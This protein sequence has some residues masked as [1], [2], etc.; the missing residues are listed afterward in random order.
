MDYSPWPN[1]CCKVGLIETSHASVVTINSLSKSGNCST[2]AVTIGIFSCLN[3]ISS[4]FVLTS[5]LYIYGLL[6]EVY[7][8]GC[9]VV[10]TS[11]EFFV[12]TCEPQKASDFLNWHKRWPL[13]HSFHFWQWGFHSIRPHVKSQIFHLS[14]VKITFLNS[15][16]EFLRFETVQN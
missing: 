12:K 16:R 11:D 4:L 14:L 15:P 9:N 13:S 2:G 10:E 6:G 7:Q 1:S 5:G 8:R 3:A